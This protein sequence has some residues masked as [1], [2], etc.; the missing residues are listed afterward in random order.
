MC[1]VYKRIQANAKPGRIRS[2]VDN[3]RLEA[4]ARPGKTRNLVDNKRPEP[5]EPENWRCVDQHADQRGRNCQRNG[6]G[7]DGGPSWFRRSGNLVAKD[8]PGHPG[9]GLTDHKRGE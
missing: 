6:Q 3:R 7:D 4:R 5:E 1:V 9:G 8:V 2:V